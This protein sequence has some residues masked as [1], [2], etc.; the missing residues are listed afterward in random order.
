MIGRAEPPA[1]DSTAIAV[2]PRAGDVIVQAMDDSPFLYGL[3]VYPCALQQSCGTYDQAARHGMTLAQR[4]GVDLWREEPGGRF[5]KLASY[6][7]R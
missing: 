3:G 1:L 2:R 6:R 7:E 4:F 5:A